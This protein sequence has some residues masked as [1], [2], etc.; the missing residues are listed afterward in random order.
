MTLVVFRADYI[1]RKLMGKL[2]VGECY[3]VVATAK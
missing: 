1:V 2:S 3:Q